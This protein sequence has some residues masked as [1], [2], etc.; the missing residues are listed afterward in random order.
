MILSSFLE[1]CFCFCLNDGIGSIYNP[2]FTHDRLYYD[3]CNLMNGAAPNN[4]PHIAAAC[5]CNKG[6][7]YIDT[8]VNLD[9][10]RDT[11]DYCGWERIGQYIHINNTCN[12]Y[13]S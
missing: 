1:I 12:D 9:N 11:K 7:V 6:E 4:V 8:I 5:T 2:A 3:Y 10:E 13:H